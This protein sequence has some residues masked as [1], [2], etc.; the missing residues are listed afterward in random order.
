[1]QDYDLFQKEY[2]MFSLITKF[3]E[4]L[5][6][7]TKICLEANHIVNYAM[8]SR[9]RIIIERERERWKEYASSCSVATAGTP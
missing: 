1:M 6:F 5:I 9:E 7:I 2:Q 8:T 3:K 4:L